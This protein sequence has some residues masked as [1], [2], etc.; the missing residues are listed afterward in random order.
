LGMSKAATCG[1]KGRSGRPARE[2]VRGTVRKQMILE[3]R[4]VG[5]RCGSVDSRV[6]FF[7]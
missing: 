4:A 2:L 1:P 3:F 6:A 5:R 7:Q